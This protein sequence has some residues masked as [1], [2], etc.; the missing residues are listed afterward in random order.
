MKRK[1]PPPHLLHPTSPTS[2]VT[3]AIRAAPAKPNATASAPAPPA[4]PDISRNPNCPRTSRRLWPWL[5]RSVNAIT[6]WQSVAVR[7]RDI[8]ARKKVRMV[9]C[10]MSRRKG[11]RRKG[12]SSSRRIGGHS[13][14]IMVFWGVVQLGIFHCLWIQVPPVRIS[15]LV[16]LTFENS[17]SDLIPHSDSLRLALQQQILSGLGAIGE[18][19]HYF[20]AQR[21]YFFL[22][23]SLHGSHVLI[24]T[25]Y[26][27]RFRSMCK[28]CR[29]H[30]PVQ[31]ESGSRCHG[32]CLW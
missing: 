6:R 4:L 20:F 24:L 11:R 21:Y 3:P 26:Y 17:V 15:V 31:H 22:F 18:K 12:R 5:L 10:I 30:V 19:H 14:W 1:N 29:Q 32:G 23:Q 16:S 28:F 13:W 8:R 25:H 2:A 27:S 9:W 7:C